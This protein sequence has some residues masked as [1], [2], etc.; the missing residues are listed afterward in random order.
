MIP[1]DSLDGWTPPVPRRTIARPAAAGSLL[2]APLDESPANST[3]AAVRRITE[4]LARVDPNHPALSSYLEV[5]RSLATSLE[6]SG[7]AVP[8]RLDQIW[9]GDGVTGHDPATGPQN[10]ISPP[11][12]LYDVGDGWAEG[13]VTLGLPYQ[14]P[15]GLVHGGVSAL[16]LDAALASAN[17]LMGT[18]GMT[19]ALD[20]AYRRPTPLYTPLTV[21]AKQIRVEGRK[22]FVSG[23]IRDSGGVT[24]TASGVFVGR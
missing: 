16:L 14:G 17:A 5:L 9:Q 7:Q 11:L 22:R 21:R 24:V 4:A 12:A 2:T 10:P 20:I 8:A 1:N 15:P 19:V 13:V 23:E 18:D 6:E 3:A